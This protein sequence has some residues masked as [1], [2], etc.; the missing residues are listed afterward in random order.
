LS[1]PFNK[2]AW[3]EATTQVTVLLDL[4]MYLSPKKLVLS[5]LFDNMIFAGSSFISA[6]T[7]KLAGAVKQPVSKYFVSQRRA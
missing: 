2:R 7:G 1:E 3:E 4:Y 5:A 6:F